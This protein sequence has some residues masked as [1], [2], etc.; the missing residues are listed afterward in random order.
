VPVLIEVVDTPE[1]AE[2]WRELA[3]SLAGKDDI[4]ESQAIPR[5]PTLE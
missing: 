5:V 4:V 2:R 1:R 3:L